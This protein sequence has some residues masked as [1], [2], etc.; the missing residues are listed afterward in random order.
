MS[1]ASLCVVGGTTFDLLAHGLP[2]LPRV[3]AAGDEFTQRSLVHLPSGFV[4]SVGG[5]AGNAAFV[6]AR[7][8]GRA[9]RLVTAFGDDLFGHW[10][11]QRFDEAGIDLLQVPPAETSV[12]V[13]ATDT[14]GRRTSLFRPVQV[15]TV[16]TVSQA[17]AATLQPADVVLLAGY[18]HPAPEAIAAWAQAGRAQG[19]TVALDPGPAVA[20]LTAELLHDALPH[21]DILLAND[22]EL[23]V[24][25]PG[26]DASAAA[27]RL[28]DSYGTAVVVKAGERGATYLTG[29]DQIHVPSFRVRDAGPTVGAGDAFNAGFLC[30]LQDGAR[31][32]DALRF[33]A[34]V[35]AAV[36]EGGR[37]V[38]GA[39]NRQQTEALVRSRAPDAAAG[40]EP[41]NEAGP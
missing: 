8:G 20:G 14:A 3:D 28:A 1:I 13:V 21:V 19:A 39:P 2:E 22:R 4:P 27:R 23:R 10:L 26:A 24:L 33:G 31:P 12:N 6:A 41:G 38:L 17:T 16:A 32:A 40:T 7:L 11:W 25:V 29:T 34:A 5:N 15:D 36:V 37:G 9:V 35:A 30:R 18:P